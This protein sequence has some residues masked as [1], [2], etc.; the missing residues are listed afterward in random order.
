MVLG[1][2]PEAFLDTQVLF[3]VPTL[4]FRRSGNTPIRRRKQEVADTL[5]T[6][7]QVDM[8]KWWAPVSDVSRGQIKA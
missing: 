3:I 4:D 1:T 7:L 6:H 5:A 2:S 8:T